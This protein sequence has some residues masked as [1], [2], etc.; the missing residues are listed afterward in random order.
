MHS[1]RSKRQEAFSQSLTNVRWRFL[2]EDKH[3]VQEQNMGIS[4]PI[5]NLE[6]NRKQGRIRRRRSGPR[7]GSSVLSAGSEVMRRA[8]PIIPGNGGDGGSTLSRVRDLQEA[9]SQN[10][11]P[12]KVFRYLS[13]GNNSKAQ[14]QP[15]GGT[16]NMSGSYF[17]GDGGSS[18]LPGMDTNAYG[19]NDGGFSTAD[20]QREMDRLSKDV[21]PSH[22]P[23]WNKSM[24]EAA[25]SPVR[26]VRRKGSGDE[27]K[28]KDDGKNVSSSS[29]SSSNNNNNNNNNNNS[30]SSST[31]ALNQEDVGSDIDSISS[32]SGEDESDEDD[33]ER[34]VSP[35]IIWRP[36]ARV[37]IADDLPPELLAEL[38]GETGSKSATSNIAASSMTARPFVQ[39]SSSPKG[40]NSLQSGGSA[41]MNSQKNNGKSFLNKD[42]G[43]WYLKPKQ[44]NDMMTGDLQQEYEKSQNARISGSDA[45]IDKVIETK[46][47]ELDNVLP[48]LFISGIYREWLEKQEEEHPE[49][50][51]PIPYYLKKKLQGKNKRK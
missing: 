5:V 28:D 31:I 3:I 7:G 4:V 11:F 36:S 32:V 50:A 12:S 2:R 30:N 27:Y 1:P 37:Q 6:G 43:A 13:V 35:I 18:M 23:T 20:I 41:I 42:Y 44:W 8:P 22:A 16:E 38:L 26:K 10:D 34:P 14:Q 40:S 19:T 33:D 17:P 49:S 46:A 25:S 9:L 15:W 51:L 21:N 39:T 29:S 45:E 24:T 47:K 48:K